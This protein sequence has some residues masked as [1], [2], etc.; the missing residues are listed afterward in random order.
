[1]ENFPEITYEGET[2]SMEDVKEEVDYTLSRAERRR[3]FRKEFR[4]IWKGKE[5]KE[6]EQPREGT[7]RWMRRHG[8]FDL[9][10]A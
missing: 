5:K 8:I 2:M 9:D 1:M 7:N 4:A 6:V 3:A 10:E